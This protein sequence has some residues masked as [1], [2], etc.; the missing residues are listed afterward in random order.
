MAS[1]RASQL[2]KV[3]RIPAALCKISKY[4]HRFVAAAWPVFK[5]CANNS[6]IDFRSISLKA[7]SSAPFREIIVLTLGVLT[8]ELSKI[9]TSLHSGSDQ[10]D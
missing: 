6:Y 4:D 1:V 3:H 5:S 10:R 8:Q 9:L 2:W 7:D